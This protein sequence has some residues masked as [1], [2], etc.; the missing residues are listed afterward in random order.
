MY[1][2]QELNLLEFQED[3]FIDQVMIFYNLMMIVTNKLFTTLLINARTSI[4]QINKFF[5]H[6]I[7]M[8]LVCST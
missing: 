6:K 3:I 2:V 8:Y 4:Q 7:S 1:K 5:D